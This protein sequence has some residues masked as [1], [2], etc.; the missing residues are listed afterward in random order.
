MKG[1]LL[2]RE[3]FSVLIKIIGSTSLLN[4]KNLGMNIYKM[5]AQR[6][7]DETT[8]SKFLTREGVNYK[9]SLH[10]GPKV[11]RSSSSSPDASAAWISCLVPPS[12]LVQDS[13]SHSLIP[14]LPSL[15]QKKK[16]TLF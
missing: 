9:D 16:H 6:P 15:L 13:S 4:E 12:I 14:S 1:K 3:K 11:S 8:F 2:W 10:V 5:K 7:P